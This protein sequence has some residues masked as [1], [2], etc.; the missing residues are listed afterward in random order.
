[1][2]SSVVPKENKIATIS[3]HDTRKQ[4]FLPVIQRVDVDVPMSARSQPSC[5]KVP[6][7][8][9]AVEVNPSKGILVVHPVV[10]GKAVSVSW[11]SFW[12]SDYLRRTF[13]AVSRTVRYEVTVEPTCPKK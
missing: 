7:L 2:I 9:T 6:H 13:A 4:L 5:F 1:M 3:N 8:F 11:S 10:T 12:R